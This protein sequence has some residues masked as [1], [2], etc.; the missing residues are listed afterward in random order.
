MTYGASANNAVGTERAPS[1]LVRFFG[2]SPVMGRPAG[3]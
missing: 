1:G 3:C 2:G